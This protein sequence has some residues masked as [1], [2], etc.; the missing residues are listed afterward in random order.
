MKD[1]GDMEIPN[2]SNEKSGIC[3]GCKEQRKFK[4]MR[5][6][7]QC[8]DVKMQKLRKEKYLINLEKGKK[9]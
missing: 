9:N 3:K 5:F 6:C 2:I 8:Y 1:T 4:F 7:Q